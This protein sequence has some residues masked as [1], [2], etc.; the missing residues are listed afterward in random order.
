MKHKLTLLAA[1][2]ATTAVTL[3]LWA[4]QVE[5]AVRPLWHIGH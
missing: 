2:V 4:G 3:S 5:A 1:T